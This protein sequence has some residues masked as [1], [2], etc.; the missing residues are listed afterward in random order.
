MT[1]RYFNPALSLC[2]SLVCCA[3][4][5]THRAPSGLMHPESTAKDLTVANLKPAN[6]RCNSASNPI[7]VN[8]LEPTLNWTLEPVGRGQRDLRQ[9]AYQI[10]ASTSED[11]LKAKHPDLWDTGKVTSGDSIEIRYAGLAPRPGVT[12][13]WKVRVWDNHDRPSRFSAP[14]LWEPGLLQPSDWT[15]LWIESGKD[16]AVE[17]ATPF[18]EHPAPLLRKAFTAAKPIR[19]ARASVTGLGYYELYLNGEKVGDHVLD[20]GWTDFSKRV[21][22]ATFDVTDAI[23]QGNNAL[24]IMLG[25][26]WYNPLPLAFWGHINIHDNLTIGVPKAI[27]QLDIEYADGSRDRVVTDTSWRTADGPIVKN[28][29]YLGEVYDARREIPGWSR[30]EFDD[31]SWRPVTLAGAPQGALEPQPIPPVRITRSVKPVARTEPEP[32]VYI[33]DMGQNFSGWIT[34]KCQGAEGAAIHLRYGELL[35]PNGALNPMTSVAG[36]IKNKTV[37]PESGAPSTAWQSDTYICR[38]RGTESYT[39][40]FTWHGFRYVEVTGYH[41]APPLDALEGHR[42]NTDVTPVG[43]FLSSNRLFN[44]IQ[45]ATLWTELS[46][47]FSV[48][49]DCP[50][51]ERF[52]YGGDIVA[53]S[54]MAIFN[55]DMAQFYT[56]AIQD[57]ADAV[58]PNGGF[59]ETAPFVG[60]SDNGLGEKSGPVEWGTAHPLL[61]WQLYQYYGATRP[62]EQQYPATKRW[63]SLLEAHA[64]DYILENGIGDHESIAPKNPALTGTAFFYLNATLGARIARV[65]GHTEDAA[66]YEKLADAIKN[67][68]NARFLHPETGVYDTGTQTS[69]AAPLYLGI[70]P[71]EVRDRV[72][73]RLIDDI[74]GPNTGHISTGIFGTKF[75]L[76]AL[77]DSG[78]AD[79]AA[80]IV[81]QKTFP[82][83]GY[84]LRNGATT[85]WEHWQFSDN[86]FSH[87]HPMFGSV[88]EW[89]Y[90]GLAGIAPGPDARGFDRIVI[91]PHVVDNLKWVRAE[92]NSVR[93]PIRSE[94]RKANGRLVLRI[95]IPP[96]AKAEI[97]LPTCDSVTTNGLAPVKTVDGKPVYEVGSGR[98]EF[99]MNRP[100]VTP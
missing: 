51:R 23:R 48:Q 74:E 8:T 98:Y 60:I 29:I 33:F 47:L 83:W 43:T 18:G 82:G 54:E 95:S 32:G 4:A 61:Q 64:Q 21:Y 72:V 85:L 49:S 55:F 41:G 11:G 100:A 87:N 52:G 46:N 26:G 75:M 12:V 9:T 24:G 86:T 89:F 42:L 93:G 37:A 69:Q 73:E 3:C 25:N 79:V 10:V 92:Y 16:P 71:G 53:A 7:S 91:K 2:L 76:M 78:K 38:G 30:P 63:L 99:T 14:A 84:M 20:P 70:V 59:T 1:N 27:L 88:S 67:A 80:R 97:H 22:Y 68:F 90:K 45:E 39:P 56:K 6:L 96:N 17:A 31:R 34:L 62:M 15:A 40:R 13:Y 81:G 65:L 19:R 44:R 5:V 57:L 36:Q 58:R 77:S 66:H 94:W 35:Q 50:H 28:N